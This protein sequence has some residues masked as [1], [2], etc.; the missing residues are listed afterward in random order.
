MFTYLKDDTIF[1]EKF[2]KKLLLGIFRRKS[3]RIF[4][5]KKAVEI[6]VNN[7]ISHRPPAAVEPSLAPVLVPDVVFVP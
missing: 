2:Q 3:Y 5:D 1:K 4:F 7:P 6:P